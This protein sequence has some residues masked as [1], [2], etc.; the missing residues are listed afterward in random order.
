M[1]ILGPRTPY[2]TNASAETNAPAG[3][4]PPPSSDD[5]DNYSG[6]VA[7]FTSGTPYPC[8]SCKTLNRPVD[9]K[10]WY[11]VIRGLNVGVFEG[12]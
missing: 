6:P 5:L 2:P 11:A 12:W 10:R 4:V 7:D 3:T 9:P 1:T 8:R